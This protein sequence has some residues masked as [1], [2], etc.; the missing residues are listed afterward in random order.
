[1]DD[2]VKALS[3]KCDVVEQLSELIDSNRALSFRE[4]IVE[5]CSG[6][7]QHKLTVEEERALAEALEISPIHLFAAHGICFE[8]LCERL[9]TSA[10]SL[11]RR[12]RTIKLW[13]K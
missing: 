11:G 12:L 3:L 5:D 7:A 2:T 13:R 4:L 6:I 9:V 8:H 1:M 10:M